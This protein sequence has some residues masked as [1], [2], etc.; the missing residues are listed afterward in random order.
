VKELT[1]H[2]TPKIE[3]HEVKEV[4][5]SEEHIASMR[6]QPGQNIYKYDTATKKI[7]VLTA[8]DFEKVDIEI[9]GQV[10]KKLVMKKGCLYVVALNR[11]NAAKKFLK[12]L[13]RYTSKT[14]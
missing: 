12:L 5:K 13:C 7:T 14:S 3:H 10:N 8:D 11:K 6:P 1:Q 9:G 2:L 4:R